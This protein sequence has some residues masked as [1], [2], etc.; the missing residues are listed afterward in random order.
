M[1]NTIL[2]K[3]ILFRDMSEDEI[4]TCLK[5]LRSQEKTYK[6]GTVILHDRQNGACTRRKRHNRKQ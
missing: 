5:E 4:R 6:K 1:D 2:R 3:T